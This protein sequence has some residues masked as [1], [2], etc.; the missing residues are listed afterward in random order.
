MTESSRVPSLRTRKKKTW[1]FF[2]L[3][4]AVEKKLQAEPKKASPVFGGQ[5]MTRQHESFMRSQSPGYLEAEMNEPL[6]ILRA[7]K[8]KN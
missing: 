8:L 4:S 5:S 6:L 7:R 2:T 3:L 1:I